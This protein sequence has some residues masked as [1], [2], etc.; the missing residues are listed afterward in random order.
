MGRN[1]RGTDGLTV[2]L[3]DGLTDGLT[4]TTLNDV[5]HCYSFQE[6]RSETP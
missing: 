2:G 3:T 6:S 5:N 1:T 4:E